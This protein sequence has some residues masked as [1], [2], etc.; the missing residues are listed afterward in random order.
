M[1]WLSRIRS[2]SPPPSPDREEQNGSPPP[3][4]RAAPGV[5]ALFEGLPRD[6]SHTVLDLGPSAEAHLR[7]YG[8]FARQVRFADLLTSPPHG[9]AWSAALNALP[10]HPERPYDVVLAWNLLDRIWPEERPPLVARLAELTAPGARL[11]TLVRTSAEPTEPRHRFILVDVDRMHDE[12]TGAPLPTHAPL[13]PAEVE[14]L[15]R[16]FEVVRAFTLRSGM[17]EYVAR[18]EHEVHDD[19]GP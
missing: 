13:L 17:R 11:Y 4:A 18:R 2:G 15:L 1:N 7:V 6:G 10:P 3:T 19:S 16:P 12:A 14:R 5:A 8:P 9:Q